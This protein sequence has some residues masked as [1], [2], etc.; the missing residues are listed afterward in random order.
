M[1]WVWPLGYEVNIHETKDI[2]KALLNEPIYP[3]AAY[4]GMYEGVKD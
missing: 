4:F 1:A 3:K 2:I